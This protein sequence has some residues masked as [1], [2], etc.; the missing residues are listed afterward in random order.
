MKFIKKNK[1]NTN[2][3]KTKII[4]LIL[5]FF[6]LGL[7]TE[8]YDLAKK[9][10]DFFNKIYENLYNK[11]ISEIYNVDEI[12][13]DINFNNFQKIKRYRDI[14][15]KNKFLKRDE[16]K[17][18]NANLTYNGN[19][20]KI[21][22]RLKGLLGDHWSHSYKWSFYVK[23]ND[24]R[25]L[26][27]LKRFVLQPPVTLDFINEWL[28]M[29][30]LQKEGLIFYRTKFV[31]LTINGNK[32]G[33]YTLQERSMKEMIENNKRREGPVINFS[34]NDRIDE[35]I[36]FDKLG[37]NQISDSFWRAQIT[38]IQFKKKYKGTV[39]EEYLNKA[40]SL[41][42]SFRK[43]EIK[44]K[45]AFDLDQ[46]A[47]LMALKAIFGSTEFDV[48]DLKFYFN[49]VTN[50]LEPIAKEVH[51]DPIRFMTGFNAWYFFGN[52]LRYS[53]Q[54]DFINLLYKDKY[55]YEK[56]LSYLYK[57]SNGNYIPILIKENEKQFLK[58]KKIL[59]LNYPT[60]EIYN[61][62]KYIKVASYIRNTLNPVQEPYFNLFKIKNNILEINVINTQILPIEIKGIKIKQSFVRPKSQFIVQG[63]HSDKINRQRIFR[64]DCS[65]IS[66]NKSELENMKIQY[67]I[68]GQ[69]NLK[70]KNINFWNNKKNVRSFINN[71]TDITYLLNK[72]KFIKLENKKLFIKDFD[73]IINEKII[74]PK[75][76]K[77]EINNSN[78][79]FVKKGQ[80]I[81]FSPIILEGSENKPIVI[82]SDYNE[83]N[84]QS[85][86]NNHGYGILVINTNEESIINNVIFENLSS[87][88][89][90]S[91]VG[92]LG[93]INFY[94]A[95]VKISN[96]KFYKNLVG[97]DYINIIRSNFY[98]NNCIF[99]ET[100]SDSIDIDFSKGTIS[101]SQF[102]NSRNDA[103][104]FSG[105]LVNLE[106]IFIDGSGDKGISV[107]E[108]SE[109]N[110]KNV[111][112]LNSKIGV[113]SK[114]NSFIDIKNFKI[115]NVIIGLAAYTKKSEYSGVSRIKASNIKLSNFN[116]KYVSDVGSEIIVG[117]QLIENID[118]KKE[119]N[120]C[121]F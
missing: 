46:I 29:K 41:L 78:I 53:W 13:I 6:L 110:A 7:Y 84:K 106:N 72:Y 37:L 19:Q 96:S 34:N 31:N 101:N 116:Q 8:K 91:G 87:P 98:I 56:Y 23:V 43:N 112:I 17:W 59:K 57:F 50:L 117:E 52:E 97:D 104:D 70:S 118:C 103:I 76:Y 69:T 109:I 25:P 73:W 64:I 108:R 88:P 111:T 24:K 115:D 92:L 77:L 100:N 71:S 40:V 79:R 61:H 35:F 10:K 95:D 80:L 120:V 18:S 1:V 32:Y 105:S 4:F 9:P 36:N 22:M 67:K 39:Q 107:G 54:K 33:I 81:S 12:I 45:D 121:N 11:T 93:A 63:V 21:K 83:K 28:F 49:P 62:D 66:C 75:G 94:Q 114:D 74:I 65:N 51:S 90:N 86:Q 82:S 20:K 48:D 42:E 119:H 2:Y 68:L 44:A 27:D 3:F 58:I 89:I 99:K 30:A 102:H 47:K 5:V 14:A 15:L 38:P 16:I 85:L 55:F 26:F 60:K 113:A